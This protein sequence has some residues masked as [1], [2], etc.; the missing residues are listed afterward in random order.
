VTARL[1]LGLLVVLAALP[2]AAPARDAKRLTTIRVTLR[3]D[4]VSRGWRGNWRSALPDGTIVDEGAALDVRRKKDGRW[5][6]SRTLNGRRGKLQFRITGAARKPVSNLRW[7]IT[8]GT[9]AYA[10]LSGRGPD[11]EQF[12]AGNIGVR[13]DAVPG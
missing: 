1:V 8:G 10:S 12:S 2:A 6:I 9:H 4:N 5:T 11:V 3:Y 13:M 7:T